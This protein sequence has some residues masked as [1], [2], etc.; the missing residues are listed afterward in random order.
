MKDKY[1][2]KLLAVAMVLLSIANVLWGSLDIPVKDVW[3]ILCGKEIDGHPAWSIIVLQGRIPQMLTALF[4][5]TAL[6]TCGLL[7]Q[8]SS[9][10]MSQ[11]ASYNSS[12]TQQR[13][14]V[15]TAL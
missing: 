6:G 15:C 4:T 7:P 14:R 13:N 12:I 10:V 1:K 9:S 11:A 2:L 3:Q 5:G 8:A